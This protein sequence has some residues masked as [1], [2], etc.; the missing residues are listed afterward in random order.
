MRIFIGYLS[1]L[2]LCRLSLKPT[3]SPE[4]QL[5]VCIRPP[6]EQRQ[7]RRPIFSINA[8]PRMRLFLGMHNPGRRRRV[9][10]RHFSPNG[11][12]RNSHL[13]IIANALDLAHIAARHHK[14]PVGF[15]TKPHWR[16]HT[17]AALAEGDQRDV[18]LLAD[19]LW[20]RL[21]HSIIVPCGPASSLRLPPPSATSIDPTL[22][23]YPQ[24]TLPF[25]VLSCRPDC[26][27]PPFCSKTLACANGCVT[28]CSGVRN[29][30]QSRPINPLPRPCNPPISKP[31]R[32]PTRS[33]KPNPPQ[34]SPP[35]H[36]EDSPPPAPP[37]RLRRVQLATTTPAT[38]MLKEVT[39]LPNPTS[40]TLPSNP[41][42]H[43]INRREPLYPQAGKCAV[44]VA[45]EVEAVAA[46]AA[47]KP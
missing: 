47:N 41:C 15:L 4:S 24:P 5:D 17:N 10:P 2:S 20:N 18:F 25:L 16:R 35:P 23:L 43:P 39:I 7:P 34:P 14:Q 8:L 19:R 32:L 11:A 31:I 30:P 22:L 13:R 12:W 37:P 6:P 33:L 21:R 9:R 45:A 42:P 46:A 36:G 1:G 28:A 40:A 3:P 44:A 27:D 38:V 29:R 26:S